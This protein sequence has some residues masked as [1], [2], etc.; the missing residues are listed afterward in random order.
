MWF[1]PSS[2]ARRRTAIA[3]S[4][5]SGGPITCGP[6]SCMAPYPM[7]WTERSPRGKEPD[8]SAVNVMPRLLHRRA[9]SH[10]PGP[11]KSRPGRLFSRLYQKPDRPAP[12]LSEGHVGL[13]CLG[14]RHVV[15]GEFVDAE[16]VLLEQRQDVG[17][18]APDVGLAHAQLDLLVEHAHERQRVGGPAIDA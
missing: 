14:E 10:A 7:R 17:H 15:G 9:G 12:L 1:T 16:E 13:R 5:S 8:F 2:T 3:A 18:P 4:R 6:A 11:G